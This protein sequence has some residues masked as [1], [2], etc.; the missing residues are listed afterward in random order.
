MTSGM[1]EIWHKSHP[2]G[3]RLDEKIE[4]CKKLLIEYGYT[5]IKG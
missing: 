2:P 5:V 3:Q 1:L 4:W